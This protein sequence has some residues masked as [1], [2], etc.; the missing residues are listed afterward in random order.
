[1]RKHTFTL[2]ELLVV[3]AIITILAAMLLPA[4]N[5]A[6]G[7]A[8]KIKCLG[9]LKQFGMGGG[10]YADASDGFWVPGQ[11]SSAV[12]RWSWNQNLSFRR[13]LGDSSPALD[14]SQNKADSGAT[15]GL[16]CPSAT[17]AHAHRDGNN[18]P[19]LMYSYG[20][21][22]EEF[23]NTAWHSTGTDGELIVAYK[24][25]RINSPSR[26]MGFIDALDW[27]VK[28]DYWSNTRY[29]LHG[30]AY[31]AN[32]PAYRHGGNDRA[33]IVFLDGHAES[34]K[35]AQVKDENLWFGFYRSLR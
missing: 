1:M 8:K 10:A 32:Q 2:I 3:I 34:W 23:P 33:N 11:N 26:R 13:A 24:L 4:L 27:A 25:A 12:A 14:E 15:R 35:S 16:I 19:A 31:T 7:T 28:Y 20:V 17:Y 5:Q 22:A 6:R 29:I 21:S 18:N 30:E 9:I